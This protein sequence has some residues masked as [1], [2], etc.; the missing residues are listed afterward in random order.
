MIGPAY[1]L[2]QPER[3]PF[4]VK[5]LRYTQDLLDEHTSVCHSRRTTIFIPRLKSMSTV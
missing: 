4:V 2:V 3:K 5:D 1:Q